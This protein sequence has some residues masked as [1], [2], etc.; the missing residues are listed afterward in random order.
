MF[1]KEEERPTETRAPRG[2]TET[3]RRT[4]SHEEGAETEVLQPQARGYPGSQKPED[5]K[6]GSP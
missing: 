6:K 2:D 5:E 3:L 1:L 4:Q